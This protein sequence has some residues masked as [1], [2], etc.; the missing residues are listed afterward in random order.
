MISNINSFNV[1]DLH[2]HY[3]NDVPEGQ[4]IIDEEI[5]YFMKNVSVNIIL[6]W[7]AIFSLFNIK[8]QF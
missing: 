1:S 5:L 4:E 2:F 6:N 7:N 8:N 3:N